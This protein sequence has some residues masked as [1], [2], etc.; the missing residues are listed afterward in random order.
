[1]LERLQDTFESKP[2]SA[3]I[4]MLPR[5]GAVALAMVLSLNVLFGVINERRATR[6]QTGYYPSLQM[7]RT[8]RETLAGI[9]RGLQD[10]VAAGDADALVHTDSLR[11]AFVATL[12]TGRGNP[13]IAPAELGRLE[14]AF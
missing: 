5:I 7:S 14:A 3:K 1:M 9:Q 10:A 8:L 4:A 13:V 6:V 2:F 11:N 12:Q